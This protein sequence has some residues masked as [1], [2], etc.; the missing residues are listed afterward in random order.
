MTAL[1][2]VQAYVRAME[3]Q[4]KAAVAETLAPD[5]VHMFPV[6][7]SKGMAG[8]FQGRDEVLGY[9][10]GYIAKFRSLVWV[11][12]RWT[13]SADGRTVFLEAR[14]DAVMAH[15]GEPYHNLYVERFDVEAGK[16]VRIL[17]YADAATYAATATPPT[18]HEIEVV[19]ATPERVA[20]LESSLG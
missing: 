13:E 19:T 1:E 14:G 18:Q 16:I 9:V 10:D 17:E 4:D 5:V 20:R 8:I 15:S 2:T 7:G 11:D 6:A 3:A 12:K